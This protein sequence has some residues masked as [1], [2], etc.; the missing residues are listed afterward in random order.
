MPEVWLELDTALKERLHTVLDD[1][2]RPVTES[3]YESSR[4]KVGPAR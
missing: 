2:Q 4:R 3:S 1:P